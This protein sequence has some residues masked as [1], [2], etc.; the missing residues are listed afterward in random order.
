MSSRDLG[1][2][3]ITAARR[4]HPM[5]R[6]FGITLLASF[7][8]VQSVINIIVVY[9]YYVS[10]APLFPI[11]YYV[12]DSIAGFALAYGLWKGLMWGKLGTMIVS[13]VEILIGVLGTVVAV[14]VQP[15]SPLQALTKLMVYAIVIYFLTR[16]EISEYFKK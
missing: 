7:F 12:A 5:D 16:P 4:F 1:V 2:K 11:A 3:A 6:P 14:D 9:T 8:F 10:G 15:T 13:G